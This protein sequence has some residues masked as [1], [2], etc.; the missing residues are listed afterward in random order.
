MGEGFKASVSFCRA[1]KDGELANSALELSELLLMELLL[2]ASDRGREERE[3]AVFSW[4]ISRGFLVSPDK[5]GMCSLSSGS[6]YWCLGKRYLSVMSFKNVCGLSGLVFLT[7]L[8][9]LTL[10]LGGVGLVD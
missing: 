10:S 8:S 3:A 4:R 7:G 9:D 2:L 5:E 6:R 1:L